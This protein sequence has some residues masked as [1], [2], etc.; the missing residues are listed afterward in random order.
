M[1][2]IQAFNIVWLPYSLRNSESLELGKLVRVVFY[3]LTAAIILLFVLSQLLIEPI[4]LILNIGKLDPYI[5]FIVLVAV[6]TEPMGET[7]I[8][9]LHEKEK[10]GQISVP[11]FTGLL[12]LLFCLSFMPSVLGLS[13]AFLLGM[14]A[15]NVSRAV[16]SLRA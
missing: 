12:V 14:I 6:I 16:Y 9:R 1:L 11:S 7:F 15:Y 8:Y 4:R 5:L 13:V 10:Y 3:F 2:F